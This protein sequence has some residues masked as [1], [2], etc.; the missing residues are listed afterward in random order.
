MLS[1]IE[2]AKKLI[3]EA[4]KVGREEMSI[5]RTNSGIP[6]SIAE[7]ITNRRKW[8]DEYEPLPFEAQAAGLAENLTE[9]ELDYA[10]GVWA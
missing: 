3:V 5:R 1:N 4:R 6:G 7:K 2:I 9:K 8:N 10:K